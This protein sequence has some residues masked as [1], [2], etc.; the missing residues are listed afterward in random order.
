[1]VKKIIIVKGVQAMPVYQYACRDCSYEFEKR[2]GFNDDPLTVCPTCE[3]TVQ[4]VI[5]PVGIIFKGSGFYIN[6]SK[7]DSKNG[8]TKNSTIPSASDSDGKSKETESS[9]AST[10]DVKKE[11]KKETPKA[12]T[13]KATSDA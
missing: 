11:T 4:R 1:M 12:D 6:D 2:Q 7:K 8:Q 10:D 5:T 9:K 3:G 13:K